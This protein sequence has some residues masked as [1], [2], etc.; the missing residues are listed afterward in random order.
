[1][2]KKAG[3]DKSVKQF[4]CDEIYACK[5]CKREFYYGNRGRRS[6]RMQAFKDRGNV[7]GLCSMHSKTSTFIEDTSKL[8][9]QKYISTTTRSSGLTSYAVSL[10]RNNK[11]ISRTFQSLSHAI[12]FRNATIEFYNSNRRFPNLREQRKLF[13]HLPRSRKL[14]KI[15]E[16]S[17]SSKRK[18]SSN[19]SSKNSNC[20]LKNITQNKTNGAYHVNVA[21]E[22]SKVSVSFRDFNDAIVA[23]DIILDEYQSTGKLPSRGEVIAKLDE[24][25][26]KL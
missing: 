10:S 8:S 20:G 6:K 14:S 9:Q 15:K 12:E 18:E 19:R 25:K 2:L 1:M 24:I 16:S 11:Y 17:K 3:L 23:R 5:K 26:S 13:P 22:R 21:R 7:C 4:D